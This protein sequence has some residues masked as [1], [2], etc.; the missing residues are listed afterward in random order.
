MTLYN[1]KQVASGETYVITKFT[2]DMDVESSYVTTYRTCECPAGQR[3]NC[4][5][6]EMLPMFIAKQATHGEMFYNFLTGEWIA[7]AIDEP[8]K[9]DESSLDMGGLEDTGVQIISIE[10][11]SAAH[12][13][14]APKPKFDRRM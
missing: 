3:F 2:E 7:A 13:A 6:R 1:C 8:L 9:E 4:R 5:H 10:D 14:I 11:I 12:S